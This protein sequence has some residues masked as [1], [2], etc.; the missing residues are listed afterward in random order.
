MKALL[1]IE[2]LEKRYPGFQLFIEELRVEPGGITALLGPNGAGKTTTINIIMGLVRPERG[3]VRVFGQ[4]PFRDGKEIKKKLAYVPENCHLYDEARAGWLLR[5]AS[6][7]Y[8]DWDEGVARQLAEKWSI[9]LE[10]KVG[11]LSKGTKVKLELLIALAAKPRLMI[12]DEP[13]SGLDPIM[14]RE[15]L[16]ELFSVIEMEN[17]SILFSSHIIQDVERIADRVVFLK[18]GRVV[19]K[20][21]KEELLDSWRRLRL[22]GKG[23]LQGLPAVAWKREED[24]WLAVLS[25]FGPEVQNSLSR[26]GF[27]ILEAE[28]MTLE[29]IFFSCIKKEVPL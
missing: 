8:P 15:I 22:K 7:L 5:F 25:D 3:K 9:P 10:K 18:E 13:T 26:R 11:Q 4:D 16:Q 23:E 2:G 6:S 1:E 12:L 28:R 19:L 20:G 21:E 24:L 14:R 17:N 27:E 29:E